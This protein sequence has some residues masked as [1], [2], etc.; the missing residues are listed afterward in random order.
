M[1]VA[2]NGFDPKVWN[3]PCKQIT[4]GADKYFVSSSKTGV[5]F[6][7]DNMRF[8]LFVM[9]PFGNAFHIAV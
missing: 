8:G 7:F 4:P 2:Y 6:S 9:E 1:S 3:I 5:Q